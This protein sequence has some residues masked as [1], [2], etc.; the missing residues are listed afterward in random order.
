MALVWIVGGRIAE[1]PLIEPL[2]HR[3]DEHELVLPPL[4]GLRT[5]QMVPR[6]GEGRRV[7]GH[8]RTQHTVGL[9][10]CRI[11]READLIGLVHPGAVHPELLPCVTAEAV[12][13]R[14]LVAPRLDVVHDAETKLA[15]G[16][17]ERCA[18]T[19][20][21]RE[22]CRDGPTTAGSIRSNTRPW[23]SPIHNT[24]EPWSELGAI[25][26]FDRHGGCV[27]A[28]SRDTT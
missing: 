13:Q 3:L 15:T 11:H 16:A 6:R 5:R 10:L 24:S 26:A 2:R 18:V 27:E 23:W 7:G 14:P 8:L 25:G 19:V 1:A 28:R 22:G 12:S 20:Q 17:S 21:I 4:P 9:P